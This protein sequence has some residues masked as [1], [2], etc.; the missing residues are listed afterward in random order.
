MSKYTDE[1]SNV[2]SLF[3]NEIMLTNLFFLPIQLTSFSHYTMG[4]GENSTSVLG[5]D[6][7]TVELWQ[8]T[9]ELVL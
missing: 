5:L 1:K 3:L 8:S 6:K 4:Y 2:I 9:H 7:A